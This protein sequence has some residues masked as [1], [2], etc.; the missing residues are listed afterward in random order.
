MLVVMLELLDLLTKRVGVLPAVVVA[1]GTK[2]V[3]SEI[4]GTVV[5]VAVVAVVVEVGV[6]VV[7]ETTLL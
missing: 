3:V 1:V 2:V 5:A 7:G 4:V 6:G